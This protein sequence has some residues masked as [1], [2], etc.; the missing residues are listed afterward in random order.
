VEFYPSYREELVEEALRKIACDRFN[1][2]FLNDRAGVQFTLYELKK[3]LKARGHSLNLP[4]ILAALKTCNLASF[5]VEGH[6][7][8]SIMQST[9]FP[10]S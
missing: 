8:T 3:E 9:I 1:G 5:T 6:D 7:G 4:D 2:V 10:Y